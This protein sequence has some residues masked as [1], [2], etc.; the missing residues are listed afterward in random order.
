MN[1]SLF[2]QSRKKEL[3]PYGEA[4]RLSN[5]LRTRKAE[6]I[7]NRFGDRLDIKFKQGFDIE[8]CSISDL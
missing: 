1:I 3:T 7:I 8:T 5:E 4:V 2:D 6:T